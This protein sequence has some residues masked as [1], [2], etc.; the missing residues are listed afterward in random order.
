MQNDS[1]ENFEEIVK[2]IRAILLLFSKIKNITK[3]ILKKYDKQT[4]MQM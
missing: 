2:K 3:K 4:I 1:D